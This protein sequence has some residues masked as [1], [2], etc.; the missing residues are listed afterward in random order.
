MCWSMGQKLGLACDQDDSSRENFL[1]M[2]LKT[3]ARVLILLE[4]KDQG[5]EA[6]AYN[7]KLQ[8]QPIDK[9][10]MT[11]LLIYKLGRGM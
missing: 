10:K 9:W 7:L 2:E 4:L 11:P 8:G 3:K 1:P 5:M 6:E